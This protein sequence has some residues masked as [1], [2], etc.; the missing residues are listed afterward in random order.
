MLTLEKT[1]HGLFQSSHWCSYFCSR[2]A[3]KINL[4]SLNVRKT[5]SGEVQVEAELEVEVCIICCKWAKTWWFTVMCHFIRFH[6][7]SCFIVILD[8][9]NVVIMTSLP[10]LPVGSEHCMF[11]HCHYWYPPLLPPPPSLSFHN[12]YDASF[13]MIMMKMTPL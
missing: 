5:N 1:T 3:P 10:C 8:H 12:D 2:K 4:Q 6:I 13:I 11:S 7:Q 9:L